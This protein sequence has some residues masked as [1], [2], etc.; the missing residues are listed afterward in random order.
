MNPFAPIIEARNLTVRFGERTIFQ[1]INFTVNRGDILVILGGS[2]C[3]KSTLLRTLTGLNTP[4]DGQ[5]FIG[6]EDFTSAFGEDRIRLLRSFGILFQSGGL[7]ASMS[8]AENV[9]LPL[10]TYTNLSEQ[11]IETMITIKLGSV[12]LDGFQE[13]LPSEISGGMKKRAGLARAMA[14]DP[15]ILF[16]DEPSAGL[17]PINSV[18]LDNLILNLNS[19]LG[20]TM[21]VVTHELDS[22][23][24]IAQKVI[25]LDRD[26][27]G[28]IAMGTLEEVKND[29]SNPRISHFFNRIAE[30]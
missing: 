21:I 2:G 8:L 12:G 6:G 27:Q 29:T 9:A 15:E 22:I 26:A 28:I 13:F 14:L 25:M 30:E 18:S 20:T 17:D 10:Q 4:T 16:F 3:G 24:K 5:V 11:E 23:N 1:N 7:F 19:A